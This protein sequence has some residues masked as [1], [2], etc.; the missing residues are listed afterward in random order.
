V[1][2]ILCLGAPIDASAAIRGNVPIF[3]RAV[4]AG[5]EDPLLIPVPPE[6]PEQ[7]ETCVRNDL[8]L[9]LKKVCKDLPE[10]EFQDL[11]AAMTREQL[12]SERLH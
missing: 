3:G 11:V 5:A 4:F 12:R 6:T 2:P 8:L 9:R 1:V 7:R 10:Q